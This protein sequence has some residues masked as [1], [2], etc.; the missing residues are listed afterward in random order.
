MII[1]T[2]TEGQHVLIY[3]KSRAVKRYRLPLGAAGAESHESTLDMAE[4]ECKVLGPHAGKFCPGD[5][6]FADHVNRSTPGELA[7]FA[8]T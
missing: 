7:R 1:K 2:C 6:E 5:I 8:T 3:I 4:V